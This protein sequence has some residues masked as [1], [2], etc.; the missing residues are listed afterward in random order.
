MKCLLYAVLCL[1]FLLACTKEVTYSYDFPGKAIAVVA[2]IDPT[3]GFT[4]YVTQGVP[5]QGSYALE[6]LIIDDAVVE[7]VSD[8]GTRLQAAYE[9]DARY[10]A[11]SN[12]SFESNRRYRLE[13]THPDYPKVI[14]DW[15]IIP[16]PIEAA[17]LERQTRVDNNKNQEV[18][19]LFFSGE[20]LDGE[21][22]YLVEVYADGGSQPQ[23]QVELSADFDSEF[24]ELY[25]YHPPNG[26]FFRDLCF[27][28]ESFNFTLTLEENEFQVSGAP[29]TYDSFVFAIRHLD[30]TYYNFQLDRL[31]L[32]DIRGTILEA[33]SP[34]TSN[35]TGGYGVFLASQ[36]F[37]RRFAVR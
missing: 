20:D 27:D 2:R 36:S 16:S 34:S 6:D 9:G 37:V 26:I 7:V 19:D 4:A 5:P 13:I 11:E 22:F 24:C 23:F 15:V 21:D 12:S 3:E 31:N 29:F 17:S 33:S 1:Q 8:D 30:S 18:T 14:S 32:D 25:N 10:Q 28:N 35:L